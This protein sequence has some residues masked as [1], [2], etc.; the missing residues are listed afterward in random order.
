MATTMQLHTPETNTDA[1]LVGDFLVEG[2]IP[3]P[4]KTGWTK[5]PKPDAFPW[6][7]M[8]SGD[9]FV[10]QLNGAK[11]DVARNFVSNSAQ[12][13]LKRNGKKG[14]VVTRTVEAGV[15]IRVWLQFV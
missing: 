5:A 3:V 2:A 1:I 13:W 8:R 15:A 9:S 11:T 12:R 4:A 14:R 10:V 6:P 7:R